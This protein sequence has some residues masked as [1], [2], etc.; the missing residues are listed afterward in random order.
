LSLLQQVQSNYLN[1][2][3]IK[4]FADL[5]I[6]G[7]AANLLQTTQFRLLPW[8]HA[9]HPNNTNII[10]RRQDK[11]QAFFEVTALPG[12]HVIDI[13]ITKLIIVSAKE[14]I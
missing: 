9:K 11:S 8:S 5:K 14:V 7:T 1:I 4:S 13:I 12:W 2:K 10:T 3:F 6:R